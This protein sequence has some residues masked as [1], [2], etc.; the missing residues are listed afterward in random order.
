MCADMLCI[1]SAYL[2]AHQQST[3]YKMVISLTVLSFAGSNW[4]AEEGQDFIAD[5]NSSDV[6]F[7]TIH[8]WP[9]NWK[10]LQNYSMRFVMVKRRRLNSVFCL[11]SILPKRCCLGESPM[12]CANL[13]QVL[14]SE[15]QRTWIRMHAEHAKDVLHKPVCALHLHII[16]HK[17][18]QLQRQPSGSA[19]ETHFA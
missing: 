13:M 18:T 6:D 14:D 19:M 16:L 5:H 4:A 9:D 3:T 10:V 11:N 1:P 15:F 2:S 8:C 17:E 12:H 7:A